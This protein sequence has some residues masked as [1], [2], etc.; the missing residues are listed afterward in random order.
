MIAETHTCN[1]KV[2]SDSGSVATAN[3]GA[4]FRRQQFYLFASKRIVRLTV[5][6]RLAGN[7]EAL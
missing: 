3:S 4:K 1:H 2:D 7:N 6:T 5:A